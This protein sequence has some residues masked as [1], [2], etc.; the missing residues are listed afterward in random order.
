[1]ITV[2]KLLCLTITVCLCICILL[3]SCSSGDTEPTADGAMTAV[4]D[5]SGNVTGYERRYHNTDGNISRLDVYDA[6]QEYLSFVLYEYYDDGSLYTET[7]YA[8]D[9]IAQSRLIYIYDDDGALY[10]KAYELPNGEATVETFDKDGNVVERQYYDTDEKLY[11]REALEDGEWKTYEGGE[12][13]TE[14]PTESE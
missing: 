10:Q 8:A 2:K 1:M 12:L 5:S 6:D 4:T 7:T 14:G 13:S 3:C 9:G 11:K